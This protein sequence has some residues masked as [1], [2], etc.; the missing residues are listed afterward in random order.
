MT[1]AGRGTEDRDGGAVIGARELSAGYGGNM[2]LKGLSLAIRAGEFA[3]FRGPNGAGKSTFLKLC[4]GMLR[5]A[6]GSIRVLGAEPWGRE[7]RRL[8][9]RMAYVPQNTA[10]PGLPVTVREAVSMGLYGRIGFFRPM[11]RGQRDLVEQAM[12]ACGV[13]PLADKR[14]QELSGGQAQRTAI[15]RALAMDA[16]LLLLD[17]PG[18]NLDAEG[19]GGLLRAIQEKREGRRLTVVVVS[20]DEDTL[21]ACG[22][23]Y[24]FNEGRAAVVDA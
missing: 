2:V 22:V 1:G 8:R 10:V 5:P 19:R 9:L 13:G 11:T 16:E 24:R 12:E 7:G 20:H 4:L 14:V 21:R 15:A 18:S 23:V 3:G 17:E 6:A